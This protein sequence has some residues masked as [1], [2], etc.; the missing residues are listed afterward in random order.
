MVT[1]EPVEPVESVDFIREAIE[2]DIQANTYGGRVQTRF[3]P[4]PNGYL[5]IGHA[6]SICLNFGVA[7]DYGGKCNLRFD[8]TNPTKEKS[9]YV[10]S[11][12]HDIQ[13]LGFDWGDKPYFASDYFG[14]LYNMAI[15]L[16]KD[17]HAYVD[18][19]S[20][21]DIRE[22]RGT[23]TEPGE[24]SPY[25][26]RSIEENLDLFE[27]MR[28]GEFPEGARVLRAKIDMAAPN[29]YLRDPVLYRILYAEHHRV[30]N[31]WPIYPLYDFTHGQSDALEKVTHS[32]CTLEF[33]PHRPLYNWFLEK[34]E[35]YPSKQIEFAPLQLTYIVTSK[36]RLLRLVEDGHV[37]GWDDPRM[38]T[39]AGMRRLGYTP[40]ALRNLCTQV[41]VAKT[42]STVEIEL[43]EHFVRQDLNKITNRVLGVLDPL[44][45]V[46]EN[47]P[48]GQTEEF[49]AINNPE[50]PESGTR[51]L[52]FSREIYIDRH[53][54]MEDPPRKFFRLSPGSEVRLRY[55]C[56]I[57]CT[58]VIKDENGEIVELR[59]K[60]DPESRGGSAPDGR[61][62]RGTI[63]WVSAQHAIPV[64]VRLYDRLYTKENPYE[65]DK[66]AVFK[67]GEE[68]L[69][70]LNSDSLK[71][72][73]NALVEPS[74]AGA[75]IGSRYQF[76]RL[77]Y[78]IV[79]PDST[80]SQLVF[81]RTISLRD[82]W[83]K[84]QKANAKNKA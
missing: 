83:K 10:D 15:K 54:F 50:N 5:H 9:D 11:I 12:M 39:L 76:E 37:T 34:L 72:I 48:E 2:Q 61:R 17:G 33:E 16:I 71:V 56:L 81:N 66:G 64:E 24:N 18:D 31:E 32:L 79:D 40:K 52:P 78:F 13:W 20:A 49:E 35:L 1:M 45:V 80:N 25:R 60:W 63:H 42:N 19:L 28:A 38:P 58:E 68:F 6:K 26:N 7:A 59:A 41:G 82:T 73:Q 21:E 67:E 55:A 8:D 62:V 74:L 57:T 43:L 44:K 36:R 29:L 75:E 23:L 65:A 4:E 69:T 27:R 53:D 22:A 77:G 51:M 46:I 84:I 14:D 3:P 47:Y 30:G 70:N